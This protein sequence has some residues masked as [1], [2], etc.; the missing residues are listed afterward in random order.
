MTAW[1][2][3]AHDDRGS[4]LR[5][6]AVQNMLGGFG[7]LATKSERMS[8]VFKMEIHHAGVDLPRDGFHLIT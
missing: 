3:Q 6:T 5:V 4:K 8:F 2:P 1:T 7:A